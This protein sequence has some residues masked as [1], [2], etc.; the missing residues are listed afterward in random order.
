MNEKVSTLPVSKLS[1][2]YDTEFKPSESY[3]DGMPDLQNSDFHDVP[4]EFVGIE[5]FKLP[6]KLRTREGSYQE[7][8]ASIGGSVSLDASKRGINMSRIIRT[9]YKSKDE[10]FTIDALVDVLRNYKKDLDTFDAHI[11]MNFQYHLWQDALRSVKS[12]GTP[13]GGWQFYNI[14]FDVNID[15]NDEVKKIMW[16]D[17]VYSSACPCSTELSIYAGETRG[18][19]GIPHS[20]RSVARIG[21]EFEDFLWI[22][23]I[24]DM[25]KEKLQTET[26]VFCKRADE[27]AFAEKNGANV[28][29]V[30]DAVRLLYHGLND[31]KVVKDFKVIVLHAESLH[32]HNA[33]SVITKGVK[34][35]IFKHHVSLEVFKDMAHSIA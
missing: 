25:C 35:S 24:I 8:I 4:I 5:N 10:V 30:E 34:N 28:K 20:Q 21:V 6:I 11:M 14:T 12:D 23:D 9:A 1:R 22:E 33:L 27:Q 2:V 15:K 32:S 29:F 18:V 13:E 19:Y 31:M 3:L 26:L 16:V 7:T 17:F